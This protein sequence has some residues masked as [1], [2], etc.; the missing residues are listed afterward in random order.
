MKATI[1]TFTIEHYDQVFDLWKSCEGVGLSE[2]DSK[3]N[4]EKFLR[5]NKGL[6]LIAKQGKE[7]IGALL[8]GHDG[9]RGYIHH[10]AVSPHL[11]RNGIG[12]GLVE[13]GIE[14]LKA[15]GIKKCHIFV[16][17]KNE[18]GKHFWE[19]CGWEYR[20]E[21]GIISKIIQ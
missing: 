11:R 10:L 17:K 1:S 20:E 19:K 9:R 15:I 3:D 4:I 7:I 18:S 16:F 21:L 2:A 12:K 14:R 5:H 8:V 13:S 6:S